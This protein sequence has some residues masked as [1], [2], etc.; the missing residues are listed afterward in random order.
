MPF[1]RLTFLLAGIYGILV[2]AP[3]YFLETRYGQDHPP[4]ITHAEFFYGFVGVCLV[5]Q[6]LFLVIASDP[7]RFRPIMLI[8]VLE[9]ISF[10]VP[11]AV[12]YLQGRLNPLV[13]FFAFTDFIWAAL[14]IAAYLQTPHKS[15]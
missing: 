12:L 13:M 8:G 2:V 7:V 6:I 15:P 3:E 4:A 9:K 14:F 5:F 11:A 10:F 1:P